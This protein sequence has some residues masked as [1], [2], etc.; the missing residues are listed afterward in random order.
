MERRGIVWVLFSGN[1]LWQNFNAHSTIKCRTIIAKY[2]LLMFHIFYSFLL[3]ILN[4]RCIRKLKRL[5]IVGGMYYFVI[6]R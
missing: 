4:N 3:Y 1:L 5:F 2:F 6:I